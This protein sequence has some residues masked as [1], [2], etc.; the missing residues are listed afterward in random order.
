MATYE[1]LTAISNEVFV[2]VGIF[3][4]LHWSDSFPDDG[5]L[6]RLVT[7]KGSTIEAGILLLQFYDVR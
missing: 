2:D 7:I 1:P 3:A 4:I 6:G 5:S